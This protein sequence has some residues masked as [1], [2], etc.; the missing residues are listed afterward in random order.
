MS[1]TTTSTTPSPGLELDEVPRRGARSQ[2]V[3]TGLAGVAMLALQF[4]GQALISTEAA[5]PA[6]D[7]PA[8]EIHTFFAAND[9]S[10][11]A[12]GSYLSALSVLAALFFA[13]GLA[14]LLRRDWRAPLVLACGLGYALAVGVGW[15]LA[16][17]RVEEGLN[18]DLARL[19]FDLGNL[20][21]ATAWVALGGFTVVTGCALRTHRLAPAWVAWM[22]AVAGICA[23]AARAVWTSPFWLVGYSLFLVWTLA[24]CAVLLARA[25]RADTS[26]PD[27][28][29][30][31]EPSGALARREES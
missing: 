13:G 9:P 6:F 14:S 20:S 23:V 21:F 29:H 12:A 28:H 17:T 16:A 7:A 24:I 8:S 1:T 5:E 10:L 27:R 30:G 15:E 26:D 2:L 3:T 19:A 25:F 4:T 18:P 11:M 22:G 31:F